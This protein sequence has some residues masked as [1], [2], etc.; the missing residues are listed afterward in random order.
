MSKSGRQALL[1][2]VGGCILQ[3]RAALHGD[4]EDSFQNIAV[5]WNSYFHVKYYGDGPDINS[6][7]VA[8]M[9]SL[10][11]MARSVRNPTHLDNY[12]DG[13]GYMLLA[14]ENYGD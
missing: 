1:D 3:D 11:K 12:V 14:G 2:A 13:A 5:L 4:P 8:F 9:M 10:L 6:Q 7:D